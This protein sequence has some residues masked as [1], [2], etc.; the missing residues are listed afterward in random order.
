MNPK[1]VLVALLVVTLLGA[2]TDAMLEGA[3]SSSS[4]LPLVMGL[5]TNFLCFYWYRLDSERRGYQRS[6]GL[7]V[8]IILLAVA[9]MPYYMV[10][11]RP[12]GEKG[13]A[14]LRLAGFVLLLMAAAFVGSFIGVVAT[15]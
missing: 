10:R 15:A 13:R 1:N 7:N 9:A 11:S 4:M 14:L 8:A 6:L 12:Q 2:V 3:R 5:L